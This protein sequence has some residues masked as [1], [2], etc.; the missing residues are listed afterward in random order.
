LIAALFW[1]FVG[2]LFVQLGTKIVAKFTPRY[3]TAFWA[4]LFNGLVIIFTG[5]AYGAM[6][7]VWDLEPERGTLFVFAINFLAQASIHK[8][9]LK[10]PET[11]NIS[12]KKACLVTLIQLV[13][14]VGLV[15]IT[16]GILIALG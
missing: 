10:H 12:Y 8:F 13:L 1:A 7:Y 6:V 15:V 14:S 4:V 5:F 2:A 9:L 16:A 11:G 3:W